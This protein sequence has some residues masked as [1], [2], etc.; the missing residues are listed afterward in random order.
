M[1]I[2]VGNMSFDTGE[3]DLRK[4]FEEHGTVDT[5]SIITDRDTG[6]PKGFGFIE[7][8][9]DTEAQ[10]A[11]DNLNDK[12]FMGR[13]LKVNQARP[14]NDNRGGGGGRGGGGFG[15]GGY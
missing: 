1:K 11:I 15:R 6:R 9:N 7:M 12:D 8:S 2:Y 4:A 14:R 5:I 13:T 3:S 10:A